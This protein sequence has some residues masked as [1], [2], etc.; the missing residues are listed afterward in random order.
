MTFINLALVCNNVHRNHFGPRN[1]KCSHVYVEFP[2]YFS[3]VDLNVAAPLA[4]DETENMDLDADVD[5][6]KLFVIGLVLVY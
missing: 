5:I 6:G 1:I 2:L 4:T 3:V